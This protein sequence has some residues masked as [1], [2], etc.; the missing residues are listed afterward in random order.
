MTV[1]LCCHHNTASR[2]EYYCL[3]KVWPHP[4]RHKADKADMNGPMNLFYCH[5]VSESVGN[6]TVEAR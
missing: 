3:D 4:R 1:L 5:S 6:N 2:Q